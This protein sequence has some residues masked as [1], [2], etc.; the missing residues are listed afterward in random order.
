MSDALALTT[1]AVPDT[2]EP[3]AGAVIDTVGAWV[4]LLTVTLTAEAVF[5]LPAASNAFAYRPTVPFATVVEFQV[6]LN[7]EVVSVPIRTPA[8]R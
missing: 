1:T 8:P 7:G 6:M 4:S 5:E 2:V 3:F